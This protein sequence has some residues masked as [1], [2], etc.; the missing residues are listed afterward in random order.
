M[1][2]FSLDFNIK[3]LDLAQPF[4][5]A[6][7]TKNVVPN[8]IVE[9]SGKGITGY[10]EADPNKRYDE[11]AEKVCAFLEGLSP[12]FF[13]DVASAEQLKNKLDKVLG[14]PPQSAKSALEMAW[15][16]W[17]AKREQQP[18]WKLWNTPSNV[19]PVTSYTIGLDTVEVMQKKVEAVEQYPVLKVKLGTD[20]DREII[21]GIREITD[22]PIRVDANEG[23]T[24]L[25][26]AQEQI[27]FLAEQ[28]IAIVE[29]PM[30]AAM[31]KEMK[32]LKQWSPLPL[33]ADESFKGSESLD[34][35]AQSFHIINIKLSKIGSMVK[36]KNVINQAHQL[37]LKV[38]IGCMVS[39]SL[40]IAAGALLGTMVEYVDLDGHLLIKDDLF[41]GLHMNSN[42]Q[43]VLNDKPGLGVVKR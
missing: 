31:K 18:L 16:D 2:H 6:R 11:D 23:W 19:T 17:W 42:Q 26:E 24:S 38:M 36:A 9:L 10:G 37:G 7:G 25:E 15:L 40:A 30:P 8:V 41:N 35:V 5:I 20:R 32:V 4:T 28:D 27:T 13:D 1:S 34:E 14:T 12:S 43:L 22:K 33:M 3:E 21:T 29:Q 39:S